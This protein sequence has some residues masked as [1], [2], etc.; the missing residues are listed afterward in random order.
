MEEHLE[1]VRHLPPLVSALELMVPD[2]NLPD[3]TFGTLVMEIQEG[4]IA[5]EMTSQGMFSPFS[6]SVCI[7]PSLL[8]DGVVARLQLCVPPSSSSPHRPRVCA[9]T[10]RHSC[11]CPPCPSAPHLGPSLRIGTVDADPVPRDCPRR[12]GPRRPCACRQRGRSCFCPRWRCSRAGSEVQLVLEQP[13]S[14]TLQQ[15]QRR[16]WNQ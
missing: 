11:C 9:R 7:L 12:P 3:A 1:L 5:T 2:R 14:R 8:A 15:R 4:R 10:L 6:R 16:V 13:G